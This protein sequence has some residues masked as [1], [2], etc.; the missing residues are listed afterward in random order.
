MSL[1]TITRLTFR[2]ASRKKIL[3][4]AILLG[5][6][7][8]LIYA[9]GFHFIITDID[10]ELLLSNPLQLNEIRNF[11]LT[12][13]VFVV[14]FLVAMM[15]VLTSI[16][17]ISGEIQSGTIQSLA[18]KPIQRWEILIGKYLGFAA[19]ISGYILLMFGGVMSVVYVRTG[20]IAPHPVN[21][22]FLI[23]LTAMLLLSITI[24]GGT[25]LSTLANG[26]LVFGLYGIAFIGGWI[27]QIGS[28]LPDQTAGRTAVNIGIITSL[29]MP[30]E[31]LWKRAVHELQSPIVAALGFSPFSAAYYPSNLMLVYAVLYSLIALTLGIHFFSNRDL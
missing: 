27:E 22:F 31:A 7:F 29:I 26:V 30:S 3:L 24:V 17:T 19:L 11:F 8:L 9:L 13:G 25:K 2:E 5:A 18:A 23:W 20:Y 28:Y 10:D 6:I 12:A 4:A 16:D 1:F 21:A 14:N 15:T